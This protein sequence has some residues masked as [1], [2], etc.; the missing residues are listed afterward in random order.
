[1]KVLLFF[2]FI[3]CSVALG[4]ETTLPEDSLFQVRS[5][6]ADQNGKHVDFKTWRGS[7]VILTMAYTGCTYTC[8]MVVAKLKE[9]EK[10][11]ISHGIKDF[12]I[13]LASF[14]TVGDR[15]PQLLKYMKTK[16][17]NA[18]RWT[19]LSAK[20][21]KTVRELAA[22]LGVTYSKTSGGDFAHSNLI[23]LLDREGRIAVQLNGIN[24]DH[25]P[26]V[27]ELS[28]KQARHAH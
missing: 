13:V 1:M 3:F 10:A 5:E 6:W 24:A 14:D 22:L 4:D 17:M 7:P 23:T 18:E 20:S 2:S 28:I 9:I 15:P 8:P 11:L 26:L 16:D 27:K 25:G 12:K 21:D 19:M